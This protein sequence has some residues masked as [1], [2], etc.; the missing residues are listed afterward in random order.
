MN[1]LAAGQ[2]YKNCAYILKCFIIMYKQY[3]RE[4]VHINHE[5]VCNNKWIFYSNDY[6]Y[7]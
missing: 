2:Q 3:K 5:S 6:F 7:L 1:L 4:L